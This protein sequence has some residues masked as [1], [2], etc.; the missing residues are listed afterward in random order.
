MNVYLLFLF[1]E[2]HQRAFVLAALAHTSPSIPLSLFTETRAW[3]LTH[4]LLQAFQAVAMETQA[5]V[6]AIGHC[7]T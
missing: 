2:G 5:N 7:P 6:S 3:E 4:L 1:S